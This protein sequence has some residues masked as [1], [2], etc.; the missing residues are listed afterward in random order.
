M[1]A[2]DDVNALSAPVIH[3]GLSAAIDLAV[4]E[5]LAESG[6]KFHFGLAIDLSLNIDSVISFEG[7]VRLPI[8]RR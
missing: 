6:A 8:L 3:H 4:D 5:N 1:N 7:Y 2:T